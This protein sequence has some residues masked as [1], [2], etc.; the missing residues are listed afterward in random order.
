MYFLGCNVN[1]KSYNNVAK[2]PSTFIKYKSI[3][4]Q[5]NGFIL[6]LNIS[7]LFV[8]ELNYKVDLYK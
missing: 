8:L 5:I 3:K 7:T 2:S 6:H 4:I 1:T